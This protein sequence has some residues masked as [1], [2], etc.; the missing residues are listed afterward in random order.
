MPKDFTPYLASIDGQH[1][2]MV[3]LVEAWSRINSGSYHLAGLER[4]Q[5]ALKAGFAPLG[6]TAEEIELA[7]MTSVDSKGAVKEIPLGKALRF[8]KRP[9]APFRV[10]LGGHMDTVFPAD[11]PFQTPVLRDANTLNG[12]GVADLKGGLVAMLVALETLEASPFAENIGWEIVLNP[13]EEIGSIGSAPLLAESARRNHLG[14]IYEPALADGTLAGARKGSGNF[15]VVVHGRAAHAGRDHAL[16]RNA[17]VHLSEFILALNGLNTT[18]GSITVNPGKIE[19]GGPVNVV[20]DLALCRFNIRMTTPDEQTKLQA[21]LH[22]LVDAFNQKEGF[23]VELHGGFTRPPKLMTAEQE[24]LFHLVKEC[25]AALGQDISWKNTGGCCDGNNL[26]A[27]GL[28]NVDTLG[29]RGG[30]IHSDREY[31]LL[32]SLTERAKLSALLLM[33][34]ANGEGGLR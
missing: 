32:D 23:R 16:G 6:G 5:D 9:D 27:A 29:V 28:P 30:E 31:M 19:G 14:L 8:R 17:I 33:R 4:M 21:T 18:D 15:V 25:G 1:H 13:D 12:P 11:S 24:K 10:L 20:P 26:A 2:R 7:P 22:R 34:L 3:A